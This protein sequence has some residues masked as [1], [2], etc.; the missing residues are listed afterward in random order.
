MEDEDDDIYEPL[1]DDL[2]VETLMEEDDLKIETKSRDQLR[3]V[4]QEDP[5]QRCQEMLATRERPGTLGIERKNG[6]SRQKR[7]MVTTAGAQLE[8]ISKNLYI[9]TLY[10]AK[11]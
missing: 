6:R 8:R 5:V 3:G 7:T 1:L 9:H 4:E 2:D 11:G 10:N